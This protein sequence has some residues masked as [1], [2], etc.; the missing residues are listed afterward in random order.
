MS[1]VR[2]IIFSDSTDSKIFSFFRKGKPLEITKKRLVVRRVSLCGS[3]DRDK[4]TKKTNNLL[5]TED[6]RSTR[7]RLVASKNVLT[8]SKSNLALCTRP[9]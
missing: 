3:S 8:R 2:N 4:S 9:I 7:N 1:H 6:Y 5:L